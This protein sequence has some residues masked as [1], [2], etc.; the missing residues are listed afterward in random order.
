MRDVSEHKFKGVMCESVC[1][2]R[3]NQG[4]KDAAEAVEGSGMGGVR[5]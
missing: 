2:G 4:K 1:G 3:C 5:G